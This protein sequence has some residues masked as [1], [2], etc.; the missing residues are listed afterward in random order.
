[1]DTHD[2]F[3]GEMMAMIGGLL[4]MVFWVW[5][6][7]SGHNAPIWLAGLS[8]ALITAGLAEYKGY[9][10]WI[11]LLAGGPIGLLV[12]FA[13]PKLEDANL[14]PE[15]RLSKRRLGDAVG[16]LLIVASVALIVVLSTSF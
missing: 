4:S 6:A 9:N 8:L 12:L 15:S 16:G 1:M 10:P 11:W 2:T 3:A 5:D 14:T 13:L 7:L